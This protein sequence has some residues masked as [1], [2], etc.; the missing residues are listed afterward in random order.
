LRRLS[1]KIKKSK[2]H[3]QSWNYLPLL[4]SESFGFL[5]LN[6]TFS[7]TKL[8]RKYVGEMTEC[9]K[10]SLKFVHI[11]YATKLLCTLSPTSERTIEN[12]C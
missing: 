5:A 2:P 8:F 6:T 11:S 3:C 1:L 12:N 9:N 10:I 4:S 7:L